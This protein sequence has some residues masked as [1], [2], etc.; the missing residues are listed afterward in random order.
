MWNQK[1]ISVF[2][3]GIFVSGLLAACL[4]VQA[5]HHEDKA[6]GQKDKSAHFKSGATDAASLLKGAAQINLTTIRYADLASQKAES[7]ELKRFAQQLKQDHQQAQSELQT[8]AQKHN[9][10]LPTTVSQECLEEVAKLEAKSGRE[11][12]QAFAKGSVEGHAMAIA[13]L[14]EASTK[15]QDA[16]VRQYTSKVLDKV[17]EH[18]RQGRQVAMAV[19]VDQSTITS[20]EN[21]A[22]EG[23]GAGSESERGESKS[24]IDKPVDQSNRPV[25]QN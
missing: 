15:A 8:V 20:L 2:R 9:V 13:H 23:V 12:D 3:Y 4:V 14:Q 22:K 10:T 7:A 11:F 5:D 18:Q 19:G 17:R 24:T 16:D 6:T 25:I 1:I 21:K